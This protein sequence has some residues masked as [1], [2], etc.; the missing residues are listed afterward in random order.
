M[1]GRD[2]RGRGGGEEI[3]LKTIMAIHRFDVVQT[4][5]ENLDPAAQA[6]LVWSA[7]VEYIL[8]PLNR[9]KKRPYGIWEQ[10]RPRWTGISAQSDRGLHI[11]PT[12]WIMSTIHCPVEPLSLSGLSQQMANSWPLFLFSPVKQ[13]WHFTQ[14]ST[15]DNLQGKWSPVEIIC[16]KSRHLFSG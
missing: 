8:A 3:L 14:I 2:V 7:L 5:V 11:S 12:E 13:V 1:R 4:D 10:L 9:N 16:M 15:E 6:D